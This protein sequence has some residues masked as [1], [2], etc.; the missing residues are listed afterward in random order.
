MMAFSLVL[1]CVDC[2]F[3]LDPAKKVRQYVHQAWTSRDGLPGNAVIDIAQ[4]QDGYLWVATPM[5]LARFDGAQFDIFNKL[6]GQLPSSYVTRLATDSRGSLWIGT[7]AGLVHCHE[8]KFDVVGKETGLDGATIMDIAA[9]RKGRLWILSKGRLWRYDSGSFTELDPS[10]DFGPTAMLFG[11]AV[12]KMDNVWGVLKGGIVCV[13]KNDR[14]EAVPQLPEM[15]GQA[16][17]FISVVRDGSMWVSGWNGDVYRY[18]NGEWTKFGPKEGLAGM[19]TGRAVRDQDGSV[20]LASLAGLARI[21]GSNCT[22]FPADNREIPDQ[23]LVA[24]EDREGNLWLGSGSQGLHRF[25]DASFTQ[26]A[27]EQGLPDAAVNAICEDFDHNIWVATNAGFYQGRDR[28][29][30]IY[31]AD[32]FKE[33]LSRVEIVSDPRDHSLW[34][35]TAGGLYHRQR[36]ALVRYAQK[37]GLPSDQVFALCLDHQGVL[38]IGCGSGLTCFS[39]GKFFLPQGCPSVTSISTLTEDHDGG[40]WIGTVLGLFRYA[41]GELT[42]FS[43][44]DG[45][46]GEICITT[47]VDSKG[48]VWIST[49]NGGLSRYSGHRFFT[50]TE[51]DGLYG[52]T[53]DSI[54]EDPVAGDLW[55]S[56]DKLF[57]ISEKQLDD[58]QSGQSKRLVG[59]TFDFSDGLKSDINANCPDHVLR[60]EDGKLW[61]ATGQGIA[62]VDPDRLIL[63]DAAGPIV[64][65]NLIA[66]DRVIAGQRPRLSAGT[67]RLQIQYAALTLS[68]PDKIRFR[69]RLDG[70]DQQWFDAGQRREALFTGLRWGNYRFAV[71]ASGDGGATWTGP[72]AEAAFY[73]S[74]HFYE[75]WWFL[76]LC[77][78]VAGGLIWVAFILRRRQLE[79][80]FRAVLT[81]RIRVAG[82][83]HDS[84]A[85]GFT[86]AATLLDGLGTQVDSALSSR[87]RSIRSILGSS[88]AD[89]RTMIAVLRGQPSSGD[90]FGS[91]LRKLVDQLSLASAAQILLD[92]DE[93]EMPLISITVE[94]ELLRICQEAVNNSVRHADAKH[95]WVRL[96]VEDR[97]TLHLTIQ[98]DGKGFDVEHVAKSS[99]DTHFGLAGLTERAKRVGGDLQIRSKPG[100]GSEVE[101]LVSLGSRE[102][103]FSIRKGFLRNKHPD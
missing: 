12:D 24:Y 96:C 91:R 42:R 32:L 5:G 89:A 64:I 2:S 17:G 66:D 78:G 72:V 29:T 76:A 30:Q 73:V 40:M 93:G 48:R 84:L 54:I 34:I 7:G 58:F 102:P 67:R 8:G 43:R 81:E 60:S 31:P 14:F 20:W 57:R 59:T 4:T 88:L 101:L 99:H 6:S 22:F 46:G 61:W 65:K 35:G 52:E 51:K 56:G 45:L 50:Y 41:S 62:V 70:M 28:F 53:I 16:L 94:Q 13:L 47:C 95:I 63:H 103:R 69:Y 80:R 18:L 3:G 37:D 86:A 21:I 11:I 82:D 15:K 1:A 39:D 90:S 100:K 49:L 71:Q 87:L 26:L 33:S 97:K 85:Q 74:P 83:I 23:L 25:T 68:A 36:E 27:S 92:F 38:W 10:K 79:A 19:V 75:T 9:D 55:L 44:E 98:D 77:V